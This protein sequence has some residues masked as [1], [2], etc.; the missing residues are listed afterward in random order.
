MNYCQYH[1][2]RYEAEAC[3]KCAV[4][5][6]KSQ[7]MGGCLVVFWIWPLWFVG[8]ILGSLFGALWSGFKSALGAWDDCWK[9]I[10]AEKPGR[11]ES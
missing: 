6:W 9:W 7:K 10:R 8:M 5:S 11:R 1:K 2:V 4:E 3:S